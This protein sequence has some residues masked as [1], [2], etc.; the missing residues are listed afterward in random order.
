M[1]AMQESVCSFPLDGDDDDNDDDDDDDD[2]I[3]K[4]HIAQL[5]FIVE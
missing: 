2:D 4:S 5:L 3:L 1:A